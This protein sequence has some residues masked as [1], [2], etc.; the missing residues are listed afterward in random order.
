VVSGVEVV[1]TWRA[2]QQGRRLDVV[3]DGFRPLSSPERAAVEQE[4]QRLAVVRGSADVR[5]RYPELPP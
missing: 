5:V 2:R 1:A 3:I 4:A